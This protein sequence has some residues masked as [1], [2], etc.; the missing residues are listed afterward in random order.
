MSDDTLSPIS[1]NSLQTVILYVED[2]ARSRKVFDVMVRMSLGYQ[3]VILFEDSAD[4]VARLQ[5]LT[6]QPDVIFVDIHIKPHTGFEMLTMIRQLPA[7]NHVPVV[8]LTAS[9]MNEE[10]ERLRMAGFNSCLA[11]PVDLDNF[12]ETLALILQGESIWRII[13]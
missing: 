11:K 1:A 10:V 5:A 3:N 13:D 7:F 12:A 9:V 2:D 8:A 4:F 6:P